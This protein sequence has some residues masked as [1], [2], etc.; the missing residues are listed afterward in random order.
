MII[1]RDSFI[2]HFNSSF[3]VDYDVDVDI[4]SIERNLI[5]GIA[6]NG[7]WPGGRNLQITFYSILYE[8]CIH[9]H[10]QAMAQ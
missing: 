7:Y 5:S 4:C 3:E 1:C 8:V 10:I 6:L 2:S 9:K